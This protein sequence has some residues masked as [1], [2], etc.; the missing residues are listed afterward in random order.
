MELESESE[1]DVEQARNQ[2]NRAMVAAVAV[3]AGRR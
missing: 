3:Q 1:S 2:L